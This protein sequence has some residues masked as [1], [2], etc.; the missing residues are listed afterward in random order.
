MYTHSIQDVSRSTA[1]RMYVRQY[2]GSGQDQASLH[3]M[4][5]L[6]Y[7]WT[8]YSRYSHQPRLITITYKINAVYTVTYLPI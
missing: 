1:P 5:K 3:V 7:R 2:A 4:D 8:K 6:P